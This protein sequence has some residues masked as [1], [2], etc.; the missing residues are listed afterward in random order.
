MFLKKDHKCVA[1]KPSAHLSLSIVPRS[2]SGLSEAGRA[3]HSEAFSAI[4]P[5][6]VRL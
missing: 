4:L 3:F 5:E 2:V 1:Q 6:L